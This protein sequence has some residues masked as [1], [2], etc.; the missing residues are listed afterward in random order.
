MV[1]QLY[2]STVSFGK[3]HQYRVFKARQTQSEDN[4]SFNSLNWHLA[5][6]F[7]LNRR[8]LLHLDPG[9]WRQ[10]A[11]RLTG[12]SAKSRSWSQK[13]YP[14]GGCGVG[15]SSL[16]QSYAES[17][18]CNW[19]LYFCLT[20]LC[21]PCAVCAGQMKGTAVNKSYYHLPAK[22]MQ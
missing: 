8:R 6:W 4:N 15:G 22:V 14:E 11:A 2:N 17:P 9:N 13:G 18:M 12:H 10:S 16:Q 3:A 1:W 7:T 19:S 21:S 5:L 20:R